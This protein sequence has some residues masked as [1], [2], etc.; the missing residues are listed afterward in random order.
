MSVK[1]NFKSLMLFFYILAINF[2]S[3]QNYPGGVIGAEVWYMGN[4]EHVGN[5]EFQN[6]AQ[7]DIK[8]NKCGEAEKDLF[9]FNPSIFSEK[10]CLEYIAPLENT[11]GRNVFFVGEPEKPEPSISNLGTLWRQ[12]FGQIV[13]TDSIIRNFFDFNNK[14][15]FTKEIYANY[16]SDNNAN[17][18]FY[19]TNN[20]N[21]DKKFKSY[22]QEGETSF[23]IG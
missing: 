18:N 22:G 14:N 19:H 2:T 9:N 16:T 13:M 10:L 8:I 1:Q 21:I 11:T 17:V 5:G 12:D 15:V 23:Y 3:A 4:W 6:S 20:Y 7:T